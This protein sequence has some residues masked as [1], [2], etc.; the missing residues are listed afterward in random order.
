MDKKDKKS[1][2]VYQSWRPA[3]ELLTEKEKAQFITN[4]FRFNNDEEIV[5]DSPMLEM[6]W[7]SIEY[8]LSEND[9]RW[10]TSKENGAKGGAP[11]GNKN[12]K[13][14]PN[15]P[16][17]TEEQPN[18]PNLLVEEQP[19]Q[20]KTTQKQPKKNGLIEN[21]LNV[22]AKAN[23]NV[24]VNEDVKVDV[25]VK[26]EDN[27]NVSRKET[28]YSFSSEHRAEDFDDLILNNSAVNH[29]SNHELDQIDQALEYFGRK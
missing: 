17:T 21:N 12:A 10:L 20:P 1:F 23:V 9:R 3:F 19:N 25:N 13:K 11:L 6:F 29:L 16:K 24:N 27:V 14:Q 26:A 7:K 18:Q 8:N 2:I 22:K 28:Y 5:I 4:L 15:Q